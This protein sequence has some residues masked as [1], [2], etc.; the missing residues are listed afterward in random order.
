MMAFGLD[1][2]D[3]R[4]AAGDARPMPLLCGDQVASDD[5]VRHGGRVQT[6]QQPPEDL[7]IHS[8]QYRDD[9]RQMKKSNTGSPPFTNGA[10]L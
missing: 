4:I 2:G 5:E 6:E 9:Y 8:N 10:P 3:S 1:T 7:R